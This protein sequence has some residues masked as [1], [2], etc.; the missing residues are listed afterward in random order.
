MHLA[1]LSILALTAALVAFAAPAWSAGPVV[2]PV[3]EG[4]ARNSVNV[5]IFR[6]DPI[7]TYKDQQFVAYYD[8][9]GHVVIGQRTIGESSWKTTRTDLT[10]NVK[11]AHNCISMI[12][13]G[14][15]YLHL[16]WDHHG[17][18]LRYARSKTPG[19]LDFEKM[20]MT[21]I[22]E[23]NVTYPQFFKLASGNLIFFYRDG[24]S[25]RG[26]LIVNRYDVKTKTWKQLHTNF[27]SGENQRNA[28]WQTC[29]G[30]DGSIHVSWVW[31]ESGDVATNHDLC[32]AVS[33]NGGVTW[34]KSDGTPYTLPI[35]A[36]SAEIV[37]PI[38][39]KH[40]LINQTSMCTD[41]EG[42]P[43]IATYF[44]PEGTTVPQYFVIRFDGKVWKTT[45]VGKRTT[46]FSLSGGGSK[47]IPI[48]RPQVLARVNPDKTTSVHVVYRDVTANSGRAVV[49]S[50]PS[51]D[52][53][54]PEW[55]MRELT[56]FDVKY[57][58]P[59]LDRVRWDR[60]GVLDLFVQVCGQGDGETL[61]D[62]PPQMVNVL[63][64]KP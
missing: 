36:K 28:Y 26:N 57:W 37:S 6:A 18:P 32:Y 48:S 62:I 61:Q 54:K 5:V 9:D 13:D 63:E 35:T 60:D 51:I 7:T 41:S 4:W 31:R 45:Q 3:A 27:I 56:D 25:G 58:E 22:T 16:S 49:A 44:R 50:C 19:S 55:K 15:G 46:P 24:A 12:A 20:P 52:A 21:G 47:Q 8:A 40:E 34:T 23:T 42:R 11:D 2:L 30:P 17:H 64:W 43:V 10:G 33:R 53:E 14:E 29:V 59:S 1:S 39:Q 38:P